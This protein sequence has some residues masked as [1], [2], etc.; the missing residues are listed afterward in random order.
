MN[1]IV[2]KPTRTVIAYII[3]GFNVIIILFGSSPARST[4][5]P[6]SYGKT[7][8]DMLQLRLQ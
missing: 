6:A 5:K 7:Q 4:I 2:A 1:T 3:N 8:I